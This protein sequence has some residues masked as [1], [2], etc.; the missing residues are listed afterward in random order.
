MV[1]I[2]IAMTAR[3]DLRM[4]PLLIF[5]AWSNSARSSG[6]PESTDNLPFPTGW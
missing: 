4:R 3:S 5:Q 1:K 6:V 2:P